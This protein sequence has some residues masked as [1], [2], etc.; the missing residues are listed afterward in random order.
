M[1]I[2]FSHM[3]YAGVGEQ[4]VEEGIWVVIKNI[5]LLNK[6]LALFSISVFSAG[7]AVSGSAIQTTAIVTFAIV[8]SSS[9]VLHLCYFTLQQ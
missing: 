8:A 3:H 7:N 5:H 6:K 9:N 1:I 4:K 2:V